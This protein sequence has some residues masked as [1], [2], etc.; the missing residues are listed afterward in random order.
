M[1]SKNNKLDKNKTIDNNINQKSNKATLNTLESQ[2]R[3]LNSPEPSIKKISKKKLEEKFMKNKMLVALRA[4]PLLKRE[5]EESNY[6]TIS[7]PDR[8]TVVIS[9]PTEYVSND[10]GKYYFK[11][12]KKV[13]ITKVKEAEFKYDFAFDVKTEQEEIYQ[14]TTANLVKQVINGFNAAVFE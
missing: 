5:L 12:E 6:C 3:G 11:G 14:F 10:K 7:V 1:K 2:R 4:R 13:K 8:E 9:I